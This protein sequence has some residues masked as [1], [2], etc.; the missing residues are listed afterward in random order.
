MERLSGSG[1]C[2]RAENPERQEDTG[3]TMKHKGFLAVLAAVL[4]LG[5]PALCS[6]EETA[7][8]PALPEETVSAEEP[9][10]TE[11]AAPAEEP[12]GGEAAEG[13]EEAEG[14][15]EAGQATPATPTDLGC[16]HEHVVTTVYFFDSPAYE[17]VSAVSHRVTGPAVVETVCRDCGEVLSDETVNNAEEI[18]PHSFKK[19]VC[20]LCGYQQAARSSSVSQDAPGER[21][22]MAQPDGSGLL[23][24][25][26]TE[27][28]LSALEKARVS[29][30]LI[31]GETGKAVIAMDVPY[32]A[33]EVE[34]EQASLS[35]EMAE[36]EDGSL[37]AAMVMNTAPGK[38]Q[39]LESP[40]GVT[41]RFY[42]Q[43]EPALRV[44]FSGKGQDIFEPEVTWDSAG[45]W[46]VP[47]QREGS[48]LLTY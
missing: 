4:L 17:S 48:Y 36:Q 7:A 12:E 47:Y 5:L 20:A 10:G 23:F 25:T 30:L 26:L 9:A 33:E 14:T 41:L 22:M 18:R 35:V 13:A 40:K 45:Y 19:G 37:F 27:Q 44:I 28:D 3:D 11:D 21:T 42:Q 32:F 1:G 24:L 39:E 6:A 43:P 31:R 34:G 15:E 2:P 8:E 46:F 38:A 16:L 29:T